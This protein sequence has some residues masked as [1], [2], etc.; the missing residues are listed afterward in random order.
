MEEGATKKKRLAARSLSSLTSAD[1]YLNVN[2]TFIC[3]VSCFSVS[4]CKCILSTHTH[5]PA[6]SAAA[7]AC[8]D[9]LSRKAVVL[10]DRAELEDR[11]HQVLEEN[12]LLKKR[13]KAQEEKMKRCVCVCQIRGLWVHVISPVLMSPM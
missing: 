2:S 9:M 7:A 10:M 5:Q 12:Q 8:R 11:C 6:A 4:E 1:S 3:Q 13:A